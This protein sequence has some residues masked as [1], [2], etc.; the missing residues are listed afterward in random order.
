MKPWIVR[1]VIFL[2]SLCVLP[3]AASPDGTISGFV[4]DSDTKEGLIGANVYLASTTRGSS[5][6]QNGYYTIPRVPPGEYEI[7]ADYIGYR[8]F[9]QPVVVGSDQDLRMD[10]YLRPE[11]LEMEEIVVTGQAQR[12][13]ERL[14]QKP[15]SRLEMPPGEINMVPQV[16]ES[17]LL[18]TLQNLPGIAAVNDYSS[19]LYVRGGTPDQNLYQ[20]DGVDIYNPEH[21]FGLFSTFNTD[22]I[23]HV[24]ISKGGF[25]ADYGGRLSSVL[26]VTYLDGNRQEFEGSASVSLLS[27]KATVQSPLGRF[28]SLSG[29]IRRTYFDQTVGRNNDEIPDYYFYDGHGKIF[30]QIDKNNSL[31]ISGFSGDD[32]L[33][34]NLNEDAPDEENTVHYD[35]GN[36]TASLR[37]AHVF[38]PV[39]FSNFWLTASRF[40]SEFR[41][42][43]YIREINEI[44]DVTLKGD[45]E[46]YR[47]EKISTTFGFEAKRLNHTYQADVFGSKYRYS[48]FRTHT[49]LYLQTTWQP[50]FRWE[51]A[52]GL[53]Y[54]YFYSDRHYQSLSPRLS[55]KYR[56]DDR[57]TLK[58]ALGMYHQYLHKIPRFFIADIW[59]T[60]DENYKGSRAIHAI[61]GYGR[62]LG[63]HFSFEAEAYYKRYADIYAYDPFGS[64]DVEPQQYDQDG[65]P[66][67]DDTAGLFT[68]G[69][70][71]SYGL[72]LLTRKRSGII[73]GWLSAGLARTDYCFE[74]F[75]GGEFYPP[76]HD[77]TLTVN[78]SG[79]LDLRN[80]VRF[81]RGRE[82]RDDRSRWSLGT[83][84]LYATGQPITTTNSVYFIRELP[85]RD[86][87]EH[88]VYPAERNGFRLPPYVR[89][90][91][92]LT[93]ERRYRSWGWRA[94]LQVYNVGNRENIWY[95]DC[96][97]D[98]YDEQIIQRIDQ[99][100]MLP[101]LPTIGFAITF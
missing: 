68:R 41:Y 34:H 78:T 70:G 74:Q 32:R 82:L 97:Y 100:T 71:D 62:E 9:R 10:I 101:L 64:I 84:F 52:G 47:S 26:D 69:E 72:E 77:R 4:Y 45:V 14:Y 94:Y 22:A 16:I 56:L 17:D 63:E 83:N 89:L 7:V 11:V 96:D 76:R 48:P 31:T 81:L 1:N 29:S 2:L 46:Y 58:A 3:V 86:Y 95:Y 92:S 65:D 21:L 37:W 20:I 42:K 39:L 60:S 40:S 73:T 27:A 44:T 59:L 91:L 85:E 30:L 90:D 57:S 79:Q 6:N 24:E 33:D 35:F 28:G 99:T 54:N 61:A 15:I 36:D 25:G 50:T 49:A 93:F 87:T 55:A 53:R 80:A 23:K 13:A 66:I 8:S 88:A 51:V 98:I 5:T 38:N 18:R 19:Q 67:I 43:D 12:T 75:N